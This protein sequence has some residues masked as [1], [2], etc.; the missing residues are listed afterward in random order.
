MRGCLF[1]SVTLCLLLPAANT[2]AESGKVELVLADTGKQPGR[3]FLPNQ[4]IPLLLS[5]DSSLP[6]FLIV[7]R[8]SN[9]RTQKGV[10]LPG[11]PVHERRKSKFFFRS[12]RW[13]YTSGGEARFVGALLQP[14]DAVIFE[15]RISLP[16]RKY[17][18]YVRYWPLKNEEDGKEYLQLDVKT[19][20]EKYRRRARWVE[21]PSFGIREPPGIKVD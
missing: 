13:V 18:I 2:P 9:Q 1:F 8:R 6:I 14:G 19:V 12:D 3:Q 21:S 16:A 5:N 17:R 7:E 20:E 10:R 15:S 11:V 4:P